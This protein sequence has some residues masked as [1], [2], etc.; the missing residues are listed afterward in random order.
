MC[1]VS[2]PQEVAEEGKEEV[3]LDVQGDWPAGTGHDEVC[4][5]LTLLCFSDF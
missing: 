4:T 2:R 3:G 5:I 1:R